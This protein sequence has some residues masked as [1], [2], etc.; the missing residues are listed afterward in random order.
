MNRIGIFKETLQIVNDGKYVINGK[1]VALIHSVSELEQAIFFPEKNVK[2]IIG[3]QMRLRHGLPVDE[4]PV[5]VTNK[6][7]F[8]AALDMSRYSSLGEIAVLNFANPVNPGGGVKYGAMAQEE[9]LCRKSTLYVSLK[10]ESVSEF[11]QFHKK[12][13]DCFSSHSIIVSPNVEVFRSYNNDLLPYTFSVAVISCA[14]PIFDGIKKKSYSYDEY[15]ALLY[16]RIMGILSICEKMGYTKLVLGA[17][18]CG[19]FSND[20]KLMARLFYKALC[21]F[22]G[23]FKEIEFAVFGGVKNFDSFHE[24]M[25]LKKIDD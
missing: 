13:C 20:P 7:T 5:K 10:S 18:G 19:S 11:Y 16:E 24:V 2:V 22:N 6:D 14:A 8:S 23:S 21:Q 17:W 9:D 1:N 25:I 12:E 3:E 15:T 4:I